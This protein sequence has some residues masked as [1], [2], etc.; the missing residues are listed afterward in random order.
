MPGCAPILTLLWLASALYLL[1]KLAARFR[2]AFFKAAGTV[3][4]GDR[5]NGVPA[6]LVEWMLPRA[7]SSP[8]RADAIDTVAGI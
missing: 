4:A 1:W 3:R 8:S 2:R 5:K 7:S 6:D